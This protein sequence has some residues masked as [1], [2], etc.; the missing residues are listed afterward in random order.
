[1]RIPKLSP[2]RQVGAREKVRSL[3][4]LVSMLNEEMESKKQCEIRD[5]HN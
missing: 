4:D 2:G 1:M 5:D 3:P